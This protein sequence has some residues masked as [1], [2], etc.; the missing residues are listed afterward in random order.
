MNKIL[1]DLIKISNSVGRDKT[2]VQGG[3]GNTSAKTADGKYMY[4]KASGTA[5]KD[6]DA[7]NGWRRMDVKSVISVI[8]DRSLAKLPAQRREGEVVNRL[9]LACDDDVENTMARPSVESHLHAFLDRFVIHLHPDTVGAYV[10]ARNGKAVLGKL[11]KDQKLPPLWV[12]YTDPGLM[13]ARKI[14]KLID[15]YKNTYGK[16]PKVLFLEKH[17]LF[18]TDKTPDRAL[19]LV[20][21]VIKICESGLK[22]SKSV[23]A[24]F[25][26][27]DVINNAKLAVRKAYFDATGEHVMVKHF[28]DDPIATFAARKDAAQLLATSALTPDELVY[29]NG[30]AIWVDKCDAGKIAK[31]LKSQISK[32]KKTSAAFLVKGTGLFVVGGGDEVGV[33]KDIAESSFFIRSCAARMGGVLSLSKRQEDFVNNWEAEAFRKAVVAGRTSGEI[34][35]RIAVVTGAGSGIGRSIAIGL[36]RA[37]AATALVDIDT[38]AS[39]Q[40]G[41]LI[42]NEIPN[43]PV[44]ILRCNVTS[45]FDVDKVFADILDNWGGLDILVNAAGVAPAYSLTDL[46]ADK[47]RFALEINLTGYFLMAKYAAKVLIKQQIGGSIINI[48][49]KS[50]LDAS[51]NNTPYNATKAGQLHMGRGWAIELGHHNIRVNSICP[52]NVFEGSKIWN[53]EYIKVC[54]KKYGIKPEEVIPYYVNKTMLKQEIKGQDIADAVVFLGS[55]KARVITAQT[56]VV[57]AGQVAVR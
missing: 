17:G 51:K 11:F 54:A 57:D 49:S 34:N 20:R 25:V 32:G 3:G 16:N 37:G 29:S 56:L 43:A 26:S 9:F 12:P 1:S 33:I 6:M 21:K 7:K 40:T 46:P 2:L 4:I 27:T 48:S 24:K 23:K 13:L 42:K 47:W 55:D 10:N 30:P 5:L 28:L 41:E 38:K 35:N 53:P 8:D 18:V 22:P 45:E 31:K 44:L 39:Q 19:R 15:E 52:G 14:A 50:G 36:A